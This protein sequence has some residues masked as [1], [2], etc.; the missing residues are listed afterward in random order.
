VSHLVAGSLAFIGTSPQ[1]TTARLTAPVSLLDL[2]PGTIAVLRQVRDH[3]SRAVLRSLGLTDGARMRICR[4]GD[5]CI[6]Q[7]RSTR[8]GLSRAV[9]QSIDVDVAVAEREIP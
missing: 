3:Q 1:R 8:I 9:A 7:V 2:A 5:P 4:L 6:I